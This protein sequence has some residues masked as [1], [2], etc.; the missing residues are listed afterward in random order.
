MSLRNSILLL[1]LERKRFDF[2][3]FPPSCNFSF[4]LLSFFLHSFFFL[5]PSFCS[6]HPTTL[7]LSQTSSLPLSFHKLPKPQEQNP[8]QKLILSSPKNKT[9]SKTPKLIESAT[10]ITGVAVSIYAAWVYDWFFWVFVS[11][12]L[13]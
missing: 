6:C 7:L 3:V 9:Q 2:F 5:S 4:A 8:K 12:L 11:T 1:E 10:S 13:S